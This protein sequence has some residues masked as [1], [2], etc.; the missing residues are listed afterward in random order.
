MKVSGT[1]LKV[2]VKCLVFFFLVALVACERGKQTK[3]KQAKKIYAAEDITDG[4]IL[5]VGISVEPEVLNPL[6]ALSKTS[7]DIISLIFK[8]LADI[9]EDLVSFSPKLARSWKFS[10]DSLKITFNLRTDVLWHDGAL[11]TSKDVVFTYNMQT[12]PLVAWDGISYKLDIGDVEA[13]DDS[14]VVFTFQRRTPTMLMDTVEGYIVPEHL[15]K[16]VPPDNIAHADFNRRPIGTG[17][18]KFKD[19]KSQ[20]SITLAKFDRYYEKGKPHLDRVIFNVVPDNVNLYRN[21][22]SGDID[23]MEGVPSRDFAKLV[24]NWDK[25]YTAIRPISF[26]GRQYD[27]IGWNLIDPENYQKVLEEVGNEKPKLGRLLKPNRL[28]GSQ[29]VRAA[30]TMAIDRETTARIVTNGMSVQMDGPIPPILWAYNKK[31]NK[32]W[33]YNLDLARE[34][35]A[36]EG[37]IDS[38]GD[39]ILDKDGVKLS[40]EMVTNSG[41]VQREQALTLIQEQ[42]RKIKVEMI[43]RVLEPGLLFGRMLPSRN[44]DAALI[45]WNVSLKMDFTPLFHSSN[46]TT[47]FHFTGFYSSDYDRWEEKVK[48][49]FNRPEARKYW[50]KIAQLLSTE[51]PYT[52]LY[53]RMERIA[54]HSRFKGTIFDK[55][56]S[57]INVEDWWIP[58]AERTDTD[59]MVKG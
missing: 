24:K 57:Y 28:F 43:P 51:L 16:N 19:W 25:G 30:L 38:D 14:T 2:I 44:F 15:L 59:K 27:F 23:F 47:P 1:Y 22:L 21:L 48:M 54:I 20:Q 7:R 52:W 34:Y 9:N 31:A 4:G 36:E 8:R 39:G 55:R 45:G 6:T 41:N 26:L 40:F 37:W 33:P 58:E 56:G 3:I 49:I 46:I 50:D 12:H 53:Y 18:F 17:P 35:L 42:L 10:G 32:V 5:V 11:F 29:K 13:P